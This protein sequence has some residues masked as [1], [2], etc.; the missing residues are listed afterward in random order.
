[1]RT[2]YGSTPMIIPGAYFL[3]NVP[4]STDKKRIFFA[5][6]GKIRDFWIFSD[7]G[8]SFTLRETSF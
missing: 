2:P 6:A 8:S 1:M 5:I 7:N 4:G 3:S